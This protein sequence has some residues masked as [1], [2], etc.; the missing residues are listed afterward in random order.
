MRIGKSERT[1]K[2]ALIWKKK[3]RIDL[4]QCKIRQSKEWH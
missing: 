1:K 4:T 3:K 2:E